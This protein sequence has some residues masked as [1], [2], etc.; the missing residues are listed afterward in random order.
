MEKKSSF[1]QK[2][3]SSKKQPRAGKNNR[4]SSNSPKTNKSKSKTAQKN[5]DFASIQAQKRLIRPLDT[6]KSSQLAS[7]GKYVF[8]V[9][10]FANKKQ[11][12]QA[13][14]SYYNVD[15]D[16]INIINY[17]PKTKRFGATTGKRSSY[18]KAF[19]TVKKGQSL[20]L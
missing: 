4:D 10:D 16:K 3:R 20:T 17:K 7:L 13:V 9:P 11:I 15:V 5:N 6:E 8:Q 2:F 14:Q 12:K 1:L 19:I 18:K